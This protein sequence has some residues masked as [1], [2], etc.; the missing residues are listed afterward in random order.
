MHSYE[1][2]SKLPKKPKPA[3]TSPNSTFCFVKKKPNPPDFFWGTLD[4]A[5]NKNFFMG[6]DFNHPKMYLYYDKRFY[7][8]GIMSTSY[9]SIVL[10]VV[11]NVTFVF[12]CLIFWGSPKFFCKQVCKPW[13]MMSELPKHAR[14]YHT[15][16]SKRNFNHSIH[17]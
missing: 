15:C 8:K 12:M 2:N 13:K 9:C 11:K 10:Y 4:W 17:I 7:S 14:Y 6:N 5:C 16:V 3:Q 1:L